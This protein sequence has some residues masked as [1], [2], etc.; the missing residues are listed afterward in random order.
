M[1]ELAPMPPFVARYNY[2][3]DSDDYYEL[4]DMEPPTHRVPP[5]LRVGNRAAR[6]NP[7]SYEELFPPEE[8][9]EPPTYEEALIMQPPPSYEDLPHEN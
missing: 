2:G 7:P 8:E 3:S 5:T 4:M 6:E 1:P 9:I